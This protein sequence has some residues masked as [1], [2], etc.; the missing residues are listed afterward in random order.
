MR[1]PREDAFRL[2]E[3]SAHLLRSLP[4]EAWALYLVGAVPY[5]IGL[6]WFWLETSR[7]FYAMQNLVWSSALVAGLF[8]W[9]Q[10][11]ETWFLRRL[12]LALSGEPVSGPGTLRVLLA[13]AGVQPLS[14]LV[15][16]LS[17]VATIPFAQAV[18][19]FRQYSFEPSMKSAISTAGYDKQASW[20]LLGVLTVAAVLLYVNLVALVITV[21]Q[22]ASSFLGV[23]SLN[24][25]TV[26]LVTNPAVH[27]A[28]AVTTYLC[29]DVVLDA[30]AALQ[31]FRVVSLKTG[32][33]ILAGLR[34]VAL[35]AL[36]CVSAQAQEL[37]KAIDQTLRS[38]EFAWREA[39][40]GG[41][42]NSFLQAVAHGVNV[43]WEKLGEAVDAVIKWLWPENA[44]PETAGGPVSGIG[45]QTWM[46]L[47]G[48][49]AL[50][51]II[52]L[53]L[54][55]RSKKAP[56]KAAVAAPAAIDLNDEA[57]LASSRRED[58]WVV[59]AEELIARGEYRLALRALHL[60][61][62]RSLSE[63]GLVSIARWKTGMDYLQEVRRRAKGSESLAGQV[64]QN[65][66][67][68]EVGWYSHHT[69]DVVMVD[70][71]RKGLE[72]I[73]QHAQ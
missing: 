18:F 28:V 54:H 11:A 25:G 20:T 41:E 2:V 31:S 8:L 65:V 10:V 36:L 46:V 4:A 35:V 44:T 49:I 47:I 48:V 52:A 12:R 72:E 7:S 21:S 16:P 13:Q 51:A 42:P 27:F 38:R 26:A 24:T 29:L 23:S 62:L 30:A 32:S 3:D 6:M 1:K 55:S 71:Y 15:L 37:D 58:E 39:A 9:K 66:R 34:R 59:M 69:V 70:S 56:V 43:A 57:T 33:D 53:V 68:F 67:L 17:L 64:R 73:R 40:K 63:R 22:L 50:G 61:C 14:L 19:A 5:G 60:A 45:L